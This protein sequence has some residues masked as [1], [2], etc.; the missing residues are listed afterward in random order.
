MPHGTGVCTDFVAACEAARADFGEEALWLVVARESDV[1]AVDA[2]KDVP[3]EDERKE[4]ALPAPHTWYPPV[5]IDMAISGTVLLLQSSWKPPLADRATVPKSPCISSA[6]FAIISSVRALA[7][8]GQDSAT[9]AVKAA[10]TREPAAAA[11]QDQVPQEQE[12]KRTLE[13][14]YI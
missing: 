14:S 6:R 9:A 5:A 13:K 2:A 8:L 7:M 12:L 10:C 1:G 11:T 4:A 3:L